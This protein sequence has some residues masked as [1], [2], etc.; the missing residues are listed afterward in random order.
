MTDEIEK[1]NKK[2]ED[3]EKNIKTV[4]ENNVII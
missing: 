3:E 4:E 2:L 1:W